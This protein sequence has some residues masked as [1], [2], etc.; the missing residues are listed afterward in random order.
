M[1]KNIYLIITILILCSCKNSNINDSEYKNSKYIFYKINGRLGYWQK[2]VNNSDLK[3]EKGLIN[4]FFDNGNPFAEIEIL[5]SL[6]NR[7]EKF[8]DK[9]TAKLIKTVWIKNNEE[10]NRTYENGYYKH[11]H[12]AK[13]KIIIEEGLVEKKLN[14][15]LWKRYWSKSGNIKE[16]IHFKNGKLHGERKFYWENGNL[17]SSAYWNLGK[18]SGRGFFYY[19][20][21]NLEES[22]YRFNEKL[23]GEYKTYYDDK[24]LKKHCNY[25]NNQTLDTCRTYYP[26]GSLKKMEL[27][28]LDTINLTSYGK[29]YFY[30]E[31]GNLKLETEVKDYKPDGISKYY[32]E[33][34]K[35]IEIMTFENGVK[36]DSKPK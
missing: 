20:N 4:I 7:I 19:E 3:Y 5:D 13:G 23:H 21:G 18:Q 24:T 29:A 28:K 14:Q 26:S 35:L 11:F 32:N 30:Y 1:K 34:G 16:T 31:N 15:G 33:E 22:N 8:F 27:Y 36:I 9:E 12:S 10:Y 17:K 2:V 6:P 25:W